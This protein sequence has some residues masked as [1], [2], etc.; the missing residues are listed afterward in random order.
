MK[1]SIELQVLWSA[2]HTARV[3]VALAGLPTTFQISQ[4]F[5]GLNHEVKTTYH[6]EE[7]RE[8]ITEAGS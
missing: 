7:R 8:L 2:R 3:N 1:K 6:M 5:F 4:L